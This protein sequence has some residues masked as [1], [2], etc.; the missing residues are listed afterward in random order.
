MEASGGG[1]AAS[2]GCVIVW[3]D[4]WTGRSC[5]ACGMCEYLYCAPFPLACHFLLIV[6]QVQPLG[7]TLRQQAAW[8]RAR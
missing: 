8:L 4:V 2:S 6:H 5:I 3:M 7:A 1:C